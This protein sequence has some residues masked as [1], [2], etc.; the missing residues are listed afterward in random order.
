MYMWSWG[1]PSQE[2]KHLSNKLALRVLSAIQ[3]TCSRI[4]A[5]FP[6]RLSS[7]AVPE[8]PLMAAMRSLKVSA[9]QGASVVLNAILNTACCRGCIWAACNTQKYA[10]KR[11]CLTLHNS[12]DASDLWPVLASIA[13]SKRQTTGHTALPVQ[14]GKDDKGC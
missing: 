14:Q 5:G 12:V 1:T 10:A 8:G 6:S 2:R 11:C 3:T 13:N 7:Q 4:S 9:K